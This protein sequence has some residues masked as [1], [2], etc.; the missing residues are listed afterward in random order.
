MSIHGEFGEGTQGW[1]ARAGEKL[2]LRMVGA[3]RGGDGVEI[4]SG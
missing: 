1:G 4:R 3:S 2:K